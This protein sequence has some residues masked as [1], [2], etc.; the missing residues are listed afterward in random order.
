VNWQP[1]TTK[2]GADGVLELPLARAY[3]PLALRVEA[4]G[5]VPR[6]HLWID[7][8]KGSQEVTAP[9]GKD[10]GRPGVV[11]TPDGQPADGAIV[12]IALVQRNLRIEGHTFAGWGDP[13]ADKPGDRWR[14]P[15]MVAA[16]AEGRFV[17]PTETE[18]AS[19]VVLVHESGVAEMFYADFLATPE[20]R[21]VKWGAIA[22]RVTVGPG[23]GAGVEV[24][25]GIQHYGYGYPDMVSQHAAIETDAAGEFRFEGVVPGLA[26]VS[27]FEFFPKDNGR[28]FGG[29]Q[30]PPQEAFTH[31]TV[32]PGQT[33]RIALGSK[34]L[35]RPAPLAPQ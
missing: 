10:P 5:Y 23:A 3:D 28:G 22:G 13:E 14:R 7:K 30:R 6:R 33:E 4:D 2:V 32:R 27:L 35:S 21:L 17:L 34:N 16:D 12:G 15:T 9:L 11:R 31:V 26:Q 1:H 19:A 20:I 8:K 29:F 25:M 24:T 18:P